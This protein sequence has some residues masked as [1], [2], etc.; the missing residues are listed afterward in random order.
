[1]HYAV[2]ES[3]LPAC[4]I[5]TISLSFCHGRPVFDTILPLSCLYCQAVHGGALQPF[6]PVKDDLLCI[7]PELSPPSIIPCKQALVLKI[8]VVH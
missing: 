3:G 1:M 6:F 4:F 7:K 8:P 2:T 5:F